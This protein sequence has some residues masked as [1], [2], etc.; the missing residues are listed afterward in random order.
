MVSLFT[1][2]VVFF[3]SQGAAMTGE[4]FASH[5]PWR[6]SH[7][8]TCA[9]NPAE[10][11]SLSKR[12]HADMSRGLQ[13]FTKQFAALGSAPDEDRLEALAAQM[14]SLFWQGETLKCAMISWNESRGE[15]AGNIELLT[16]TDHAR[17]VMADT[18]DRFNVLLDDESADAAEVQAQLSA[19]RE[20]IAQLQSQ[21]DTLGALQSLASR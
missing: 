5:E 2:M 3:S 6:R 20:N 21:D 1:S 14:D 8:E 4:D 15:P 19:I 7:G 16:A 9:A 18:L 12:T 11:G 17:W 13:D 10:L